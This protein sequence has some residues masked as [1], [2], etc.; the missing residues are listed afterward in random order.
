MVIKETINV[1]DNRLLD[2]LVPVVR[3]MSQVEVIPKEEDV[4]EGTESSSVTTESF[5][6]TNK[7]RKFSLSSLSE[8]KEVVF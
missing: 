3:I 6:L 7:S 2:G 1:S 4:I 5:K 8:N